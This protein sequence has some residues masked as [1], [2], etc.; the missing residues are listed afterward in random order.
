M[1]QD[2]MPLEELNRFKQA[3]AIFDINGDGNITTQVRNRLP[4]LNFILPLLKCN[5]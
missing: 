5:S 1:S 4:I 2:K 3:F